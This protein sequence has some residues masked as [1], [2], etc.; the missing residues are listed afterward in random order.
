MI[1][2][3]GL[4]PWEF[5]FPFPGSLTS[6][7]PAVQAKDGRTGLHWAAGS[8]KECRYKATWKMEFKL[9]WRETGPL[10]GDNHQDVHLTIT[11]AVQAKDGRTGLH[12]AAGSGHAHICRL[13]L[14]VFRSLLLSLAL[15]LCLSISLY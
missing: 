10:N 6:T 4:L 5:E 15:S 11:T 8:G 7:F 2:W 13:M 14:Q 1:R 9:S 12:W 3:T